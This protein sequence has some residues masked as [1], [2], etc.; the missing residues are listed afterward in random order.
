MQSSAVFYKVS[1]QIK[2]LKFFRCTEVI[3]FLVS[4]SNHMHNH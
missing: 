3:F 2:M 4:C 1:F